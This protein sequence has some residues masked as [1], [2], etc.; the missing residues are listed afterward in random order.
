MRLDLSSGSNSQ[1]HMYQLGI[2]Q[3]NNHLSANMVLRFNYME[4][5]NSEKYII[6]AVDLL[7]TLSLALRE[8]R[9]ASVA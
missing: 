7:S 5:R 1:G 6:D 4:D 8:R 3:I 9:A 2:L